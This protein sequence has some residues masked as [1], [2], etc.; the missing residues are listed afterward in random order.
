VKEL[1]K[2]DSICQSYVQIKVSSFFTHSVEFK[3]KR[4]NILQ[5]NHSQTV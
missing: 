1:L 4:N 3:Q 2:S 5:S